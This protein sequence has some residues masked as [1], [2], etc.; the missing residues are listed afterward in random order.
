MKK[1][2]SP[3]NPAN[4]LSLLRILLV[5]F[6]VVTMKEGRD[7]LALCLFIAASLTD[8]LDGFLA[9]RYHWQTRLGEFIDPLGDKLLTLSAFVLLTLE[10][11]LPFWVVVLAFT[12]ELIVIAGYI[13]LAVVT[14]MTS[15]Q[16]SRLGK[17]STLFQ[18]FALGFFLADPWLQ[19]GPR[20]EPWMLAAVEVSV[21]L[22]FLGGVDYALRGIHNFEKSRRIK[23]S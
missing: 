2:V 10:S 8:F 6:F 20:A 9:R 16:V 3:Y 7:F 15:I 5:P 11:R 13:L 1:Q 14:Q 12:R 19:W 4:V 23:R 22:N 17:F 18:M 21:A